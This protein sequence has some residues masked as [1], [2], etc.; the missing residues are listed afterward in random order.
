M[1]RGMARGWGVS[2]EQVYGVLV[3]GNLSL[4]SGIERRFGKPY[5]A[6]RPQDQAKV[7]GEIGVD[8][9]MQLVA[10]EINAGKMRPSHLAY[11]IADALPTRPPRVEKEEAKTPQRSFVKSLGLAPRE[12]QSHTARVDASRELTADIAR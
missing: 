11:M 9:D 5:A 6:M 2:K 1:N 3:A 7:L 10:N 12:M 4:Q 8:Q